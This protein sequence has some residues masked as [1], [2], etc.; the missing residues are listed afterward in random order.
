MRAS[1]SFL[2]LVFV[3][4][5]GCGDGGSSPD[6]A[7]SVDAATPVDVNVVFDTEP[8]FVFDAGSDA[9]PDAPV[10][11]IYATLHPDATSNWSMLPAAMGTLG[12]EAGTSQCRFLGADHPCDYEEIVE[13]ASRGELSAIPMGTTAWLQRTTS[14]TVEGMERAA[15]PGANC[16]DWTFSGNHLADGEYVSF[17]VAGVPTY[18]FD[19]DPT[20]DPA[21][22]GVFVTPGDVDCGGVMRALL[23]CNAR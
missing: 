15:G 1:A 9:G 7:D 18:H 4:A 12:L 17:D 3:V 21:Q 13:A 20:F 22:P 14:V 11:P 10:T 6:A 16:Q 19:P 23:C 5:A 2:P 8:M